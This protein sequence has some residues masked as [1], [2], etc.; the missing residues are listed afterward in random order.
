[1]TCPPPIPK[2]PTFNSP[3]FTFLSF[4]VLS[5]PSYRILLQ[6]LARR[7]PLLE[8]LFL[9][10]PHQ[11][12]HSSF[13]PLL[14]STF[15]HLSPLASPFLFPLS[16]FSP[17]HLTLFFFH[18]LFFRPLISLFLFL[19]FF[20]FLLPFYSFLFTST[21]VVYDDSYLLSRTDFATVIFSHRSGSHGKAFDD[22][23]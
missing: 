10:P 8:P 15:S 22:S 4:H 17:S 1:M 16:L 12:P 20:F 7:F 11:L 9:S 5:S 3:Y 18:F 23:F 13:S 19:F 6:L 14:L 2:T 21:K